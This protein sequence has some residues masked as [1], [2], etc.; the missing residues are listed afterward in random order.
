MRDIILI[1]LMVVTAWVAA[2]LIKFFIDCSLNKRPNARIF[3]SYGG[4]PSAHST[5]VSALCTSILLVQGLSVS[6]L[7]SLVLAAVVIRDTITL[8]QYI[9]KNSRHIRE[10][11][12]HSIEIDYISHSI[13]EIIVGIAIGVIVPSIIYLIL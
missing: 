13:I 5:L 7:V 10:L 6:F 4:F 1:V 2:E 9:D 8:R 3:L 11:S 12:N